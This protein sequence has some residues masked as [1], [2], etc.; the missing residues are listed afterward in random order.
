VASSF[1]DEQNKLTLWV[2]RE[3]AL[4][5]PE[6][7]TTRRA[8][9]EFFRKQKAKAGWS[10]EQL[11]EEFPELIPIKVHPYFSLYKSWFLD[12]TTARQE[13]VNG[14]LPISYSEILAYCQL[15]DVRLVPDDVVVLKRMDNA[16]LRVVSKYFQES[17]KK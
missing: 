3:T 11:D 16:F 7:N 9:M 13:G 17:S 2:E 12:L 10:E 5:L 15:M 1:E 6:G 14:P 8:N 4:N